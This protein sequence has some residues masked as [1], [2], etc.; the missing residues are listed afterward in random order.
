ME[1]E[2]NV[3]DPERDTGSNIQFQYMVEAIDLDVPKAGFEHD[4]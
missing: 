3:L 4:F 2:K 1:C